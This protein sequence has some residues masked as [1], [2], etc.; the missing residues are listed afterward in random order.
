MVSLLILWFVLAL[1][2][3]DI[4]LGLLGGFA[5]GIVL[6]HVL[7]IVHGKALFVAFRFV[8]ALQFFF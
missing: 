7:G 4:V 8:A 2:V 3:V 1:L 5:F 6:G